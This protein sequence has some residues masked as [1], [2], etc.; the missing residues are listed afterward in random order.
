METSTNENRPDSKQPELECPLR[1]KYLEVLSRGIGEAEFRIGPMSWDMEEVLFQYFTYDQ[2]EVSPDLETTPLFFGLEWA[3]ED[4]ACPDTI[5]LILELSQGIELAKWS[6][7]TWDDI[8]TQCRMR[9]EEVKK[10]KKTYTRYTL[11]YPVHQAQF[12]YFSHHGQKRVRYYLK[13]DLKERKLDAYYYYRYKGYQKKP[14]KLP[15]EVVRIRETPAPKLLVTQMYNIDTGWP[16]LVS[17][18]KRLGINHVQFSGSTEHAIITKC[19]EEGLTVETGIAGGQI[20]PPL[21]QSGAPGLLE[22]NGNISKILPCLS[23]AEKGAAGVVNRNKYLIDKGFTLFSFDDEFWDRIQCFCP[24]CLAGFE[25][26]RKEYGKHLPDTLPQE[27]CLA[28]KELGLPEFYV[29]IQKDPQTHTEKLYRLWIAYHYTN[30]SK[31]AGMIKKSMQEY[32]DSLPERLRIEFWDI[33]GQ[34]TCDKLTAKVA[35]QEAFDYI[36]YAYYGNNPKAAGDS[37]EKY[38]RWVKGSGAKFYWLLGAGI[39]YQELQNFLPQAI[40]KWQVLE[41][42]ATG[43]DGVG[44]Y[45]AIDIDVMDMKYYSEAIWTV[46]PVEDIVA[47]GERAEDD[48]ELIKGSTNLRV[49]KKG[50]EYLILVSEYDHTDN[51]R[52]QLKIPKINKPTPVWN[53]NLRH[54][55]GKIGS[56]NKTFAAELTANERAVMYYIGER[57]ILG[58]DE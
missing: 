47:D 20:C 8:S 49:L 29:A 56:R 19:R 15:L 43:V 37:V 46:L 52:V 5:D 27:F 44:M 22:P 7:Y 3:F 45:P 9:E 38:R 17:N 40:M 55:V 18:V 23:R 33:W 31:A 16:G 2:A 25:E 21:R 6:A 39:C 26:F 51:R 53:L 57:E 12:V 34:C 30:Y 13:T 58:G 24:K 1:F 41:T 4:I 10:D 42:F 35:A 32:A 28:Y 36:G 50:D 14:T 11:T 54:K 48:I